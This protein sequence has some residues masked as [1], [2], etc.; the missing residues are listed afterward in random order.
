MARASSK[1]LAPR[2]P[3]RGNANRRGNTW[4]AYQC[5]GDPEWTW[6][7]EGADAQRPPQAPGDEFAGVASP[8]SLV[9]ALET[10]AIRSQ[11][12]GA[13]AALQLD[14]LR[15][16]EAEFAPL[17]GGMGA[18]AEAFGVAYASANAIDKAIDWYRAALDAQDGRATFRAAEQLGNLLVRRAE[19]LADLDAARADINAGIEQ[20]KRVVAVQ[21]T[22]EREDLLGSAYKRL[23][24]VEWRAGRKVAA[25]VALDAVV[26]HYRAAEAMARKIGADNLYYPA[27]NGISAELRAAFLNKRLPR[28]DEARVKAA[29]DSLRRA[30]TDHPDF[31]S[32]VGQTELLILAALAKGQVAKAEPGVTASLLDLKAR[33]PAAWM[34]DSVYNEAQFALE[35][36]IA[37]AGAAERR[38]AQKLLDT[39]LTMATP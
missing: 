4:A 13:T 33:V 9:L 10:V 36:Y 22:I 35:P 26:K 20:L 16:L 11:F 15:Y 18:V 14:K 5:Y 24:M 12:S 39:L 25:R 21:P 32:V 29:S 6:R 7:R 2:A 34:W 1:P 23:T 19:K 3:R 17:W 30:A 28:L 27:K 8:V 38:A 31:W 37:M